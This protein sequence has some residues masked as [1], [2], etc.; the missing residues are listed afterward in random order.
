MAILKDYKKQYPEYTKLW[1]QYQSTI[2]KVENLI[3]QGELVR[4]LRMI[5][6]Q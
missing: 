3:L 6:P 2:T 1:K 5:L 4:L